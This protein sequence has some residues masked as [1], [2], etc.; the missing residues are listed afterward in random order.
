MM[1]AKRIGAG[2]VVAAGIGRTTNGG[3]KYTHAQ[4]WEEGELDVLFD[5]AFQWMVPGATKVLWYGHYEEGATTYNRLVYNYAER[6]SWLIDSLRA[7]GYEVD[8]TVGTADL[9]TSSLLAPYDILVLPQLQGGPTG[10]DPDLL[11]DEAVEAIKSFVEGGKGLF[12]MESGDYDGYN[13]YKIQN[14]ILDALN[15]GLFFQHDTLFDPDSPDDRYATA[16]VTNNE[17]GAD[18]IAAT[19]K[20]TIKLYKG[21]TLELPEPGVVVGIAPRYQASM[22]GSVLTF[23]VSVFNK[24]E[25]EDTYSLVVDDNM[26]WGLS[27]SQTS[28]TVPARKTV[29][30]TLSVT[31]PIGADIGAEDSI[32]VTATSTVKEGVSDTESII[33][34]AARQITPPID[35]TYTHEARPTTKFGDKKT[36][37]TGW[38]NGGSERVWLKFDLSGLPADLD[39]GKAKLW[40]YNY[41]LTGGGSLGVRAHGVD[42]DDWNEGTV[43]WNNQPSY[44]GMLGDIV[45]IT[46]TGW[47]SWDVTSFVK[48]E[49][50]GDKKVSFSLIDIEEDTEVDHSTWFSSKEYEDYDKWPYLEIPLPYAVDVS[51]KPWTQD[52]SPGGT[53][54][55]TVT[56]QNVGSE[57][58]SYSLSVTDT[59]G[60]GPVIAQTQTTNLQYGESWTTTLTVTIPSD[61]SPGTK[62]TITVTATSQTDPNVSDSY[63]AI[64]HAFVGEK[65]PPTDDAHV[66]S[67]YPHE[68]Y[69]DEDTLYLQSD[70]RG[71]KN[72]RIFLKF[73]LSAIPSGSTI[74]EAEILLWSRKAELSDMNAQLWS[75]TDDTWS[76][77]LVTWGT[78]PGLVTLLDT[79]ALKY[80]PPSEDMWVLWDVTE[81]V[82]SEF[83]GD[84]TA[85]FGIRA[86]VESTSGRYR[87]NSKEWPSENERPHLKISYTTEPLPEGVN[88]SVSPSEKSDSPGETLTYTVTI[89]NVGDT[90][91]TYDLTVTDTLA[92]GATVIPDSLTIAAGGSDTATVSVTIP[93]GTTSGVEDVI[94]V[95]ATSR[96]NPAV[97]DS[98]T[99]TANVTAPPPIEG[100][101][102]ITLIVIVV[103]I[104]ILVAIVALMRSRRRAA[105]RWG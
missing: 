65:L 81:F 37:F 79:V 45:P 86:E 38:Y 5:V 22:P 84:Q 26:G 19:G 100:E 3:I 36:L 93:E 44:G 96:T 14:K 66:S 18:Y 61:A 9:I 88:V 55:Y 54:T 92:W 98:A 91:D 64:A 13:Y 35:D 10:G 73:D 27:L 63:G 46:E 62:N 33:V 77:D 25:V 80:S 87:F 31:I 90:D 58:D 83:A 34:R 41:W 95:K 42:N 85:S 56:I 7:K 50:A 29:E 75:V 1:A 47:Y 89:V 39:I 57:S 103:V 72:E 97:S 43:N 12:I 74:T 71:F 40:V 23:T 78:Q 68:T 51:I 52:T 20:N 15:F 24:D 104:V 30:T 6:G 105:P 4:R 69:G 59:Q 48:Q 76:E 32:T 11:P 99:F 28:L 53:L 21:A 101:F 70:T 17:F 94:T 2:A 16:I 8:N 82:R 67:G 102:P 49:F 60:W